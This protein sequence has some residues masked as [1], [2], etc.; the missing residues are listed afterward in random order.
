MAPLGAVRLTVRDAGWQVRIGNLFAMRLGTCTKMHMIC[1]HVELRIKG[2]PRP[3]SPMFFP[4][5]LS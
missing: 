1:D 2:T 4:R 3:H 5:R